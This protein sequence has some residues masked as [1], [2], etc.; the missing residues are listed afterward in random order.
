M[1]YDTAS[2]MN[3][4]TASAMKYDTA[5]AM[6]YDTASAMNYDMAFAISTRHEK[7]WKIWLRPELQKTTCDMAS[8]RIAI[9]GF[10]H[11]T[12]V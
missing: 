11:V 6:N 1:K 3:Y 10:V 5:S 12:Y 2:A 7:A 4:D 9:H 8:A